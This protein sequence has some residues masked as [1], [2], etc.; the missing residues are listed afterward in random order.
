VEPP[1][2]YECK[3]PAHQVG[4]GGPDRLTVHQGQWAFCPF[5]AKAEGHQWMATGGLPLSMLRLGAASRSRENTEVS[6]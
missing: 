5:D 4:E 1:V 6:K 3:A 2:A